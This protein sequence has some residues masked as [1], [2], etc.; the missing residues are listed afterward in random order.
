MRLKLARPYGKLIP[1]A[2]QI[3]GYFFALL[4]SA[5]ERTH[6]RFLRASRTCAKKKKG[7]RNE[8]EREKKRVGPVCAMQ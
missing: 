3:G 7:E 1:L 4:I 2:I 6:D 5:V 8:K